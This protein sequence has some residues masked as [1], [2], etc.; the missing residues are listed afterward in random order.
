MVL[1]I[2]RH[3]IGRSANIYISVKPDAGSFAG[4][5]AR[6]RATTECCSY[7]ARGTAARSCTPGGSQWHSCMYVSNSASCHAVEYCATTVS[8]AAIPS[9][10]CTAA[11]ICIGLIGAFI[12]AGVGGIYDCGCAGRDQKCACSTCLLPGKQFGWI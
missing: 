7:V 2:S 10:V 3:S 1:S 11:C 4:I 5:S 12:L 8:C 9:G 6:K